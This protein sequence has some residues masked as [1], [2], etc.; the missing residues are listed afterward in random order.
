MEELMRARISQLQADHSFAKSLQFQ[1]AIMH[2]DASPFSKAIQMVPILLFHI[3]IFTR[4][5]LI[6][7]FISSTT[8][9]SC[10][11]T[12]KTTT[13]FGK[14]SVQ[15]WEES[16][17]H[18]YNNYHPAMWLLLKIYPPYLCVPTHFKYKSTDS[19]FDI[20]KHS[21]VSFKQL[22]DLFEAA[23]ILITNP[24]QFIYGYC[25]GVDAWSHCLQPSY[26]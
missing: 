9:E 21:S 18:G 24:D 23:L 5:Q 26:T 2:M 11:S 17:L 22:V 4:V 6:M 10:H 19:L 13:S 20:S 3:S 25:Q 15:A 16:L 1:V 14:C 8:I 7:W 12:Y